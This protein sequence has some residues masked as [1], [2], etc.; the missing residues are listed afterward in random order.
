MC[1]CVMLRRC[2]LLGHAGAYNGA[3]SIRSLFLTQAN[4]GGGTLL[5]TCA[6][7]CLCMHR[8]ARRTIGTFR[9]QSLVH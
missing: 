3:S 7:A 5:P 6:D 4:M 9:D 8:M 1:E 2:G